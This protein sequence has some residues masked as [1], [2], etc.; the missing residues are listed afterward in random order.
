MKNLKHI[1]TRIFRRLSLAVVF[2]AL[3]LQVPGA[4]ASESP[5]IKDICGTILRFL[6]ITRSIVEK[7]TRPANTPRFQKLSRIENPPEIDLIEMR[8]LYLRDS[9]AMLTLL[10]SKYKITVLLSDT[11]MT[12]REMMKAPLISNWPSFW[13]YFNTPFVQRKKIADAQKFYQEIFNA[14]P[15]LG[16]YFAPHSPIPTDKDI[17]FAIDRP[18]G[19]QHVILI[20]QH[21]S[22]IVILHEFLHSRIASHRTQATGDKIPRR[23]RLLID[24]LEGDLNQLESQMIK[25]VRDH[26]DEELALDEWML[27]NRVALKFSNLDTNWL[28][29]RYW[30]HPKQMRSEDHGGLISNTLVQEYEQSLIRFIKQDPALLE[31][32]LHLGFIKAKEKKE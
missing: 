32:S 19:D 9:A 23:V 7:L 2:C 6:P 27:N 14:N 1:D 20:P 13:Q 15:W 30:S 8:K 5:S 17:I 22:R 26:Y 31:A 16:V 29:T 11:N 4:K 21:A 12:H 3:L 28:L 25:V 24:A 10:K 18:F